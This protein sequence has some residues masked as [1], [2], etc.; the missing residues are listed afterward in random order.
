M[1][2]RGLWSWW[3][4]WVSFLLGLW[5][6]GS[7]FHSWTWRRWRSNGQ[8]NIRL[9]Q[10][11]YEMF[12]FGVLDGELEGC[13]YFSLTFSNYSTLRSMKVGGWCL[14]RNH[15]N[16]VSWQN[17]QDCERGL[18]V[19]CRGWDR[20]PVWFFG[21]GWVLCYVV[22][23]SVWFLCHQGTDLWLELGFDFG[24]DL[25]AASIM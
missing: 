11:G 4:R 3:T 17:G 5:R 10:K 23:R 24:I 6:L 7:L 1:V 14:R 20:L 25:S 9:F 15:S 2:R 13:G 19:S 12:G 8:L 21:N 22:R 18:S 16:S